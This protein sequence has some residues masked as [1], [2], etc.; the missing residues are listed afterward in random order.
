MRR[1]RLRSKED[2]DAL[3]EGEWVEVA[4]G[5]WRPTIVYHASL[6]FRK[7]IMI[8]HLSEI[9]R[10]SLKEGETF[11]A[12]VRDGRIV[13]WKRDAEGAGAPETAPHA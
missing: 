12:Q 5:G 13:L 9:P 10:S 8:V 7:R 3:P 11:Q 4:K 2:W 1:V 6:E